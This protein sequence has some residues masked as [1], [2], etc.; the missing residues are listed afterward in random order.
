MEII[1]CSK[2]HDK[3]IF[4][5]IFQKRPNYDTQEF[6]KIYVHADD[7]DGTVEVIDNRDGKVEYHKFEFGQYLMYH[8]QLIMS[9]SKD[10]YPE[11]DGK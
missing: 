10:L 2:K 11:G 5:Y 3:E 7:R 4:D 6:R 9:A 1:V 8:E